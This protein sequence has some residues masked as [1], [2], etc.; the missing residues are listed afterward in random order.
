MDDNRNFAFTIRIG[1]YRPM[2]GSSYIPT[3]KVLAGKHAIVNVCNQDDMCFAWAVLS[4]MHSPK[5]HAQKVFNYRRHLN[6]IDLTGIKFPTPINQVG[7]F[8]KNNPTLSINVY[9]LGKDEKEIIPKYVT[10]CG[11]RQKHIDLLLLTSDEKSHYV[12]IKNMSALICHRSKCK[13]AVFVCP[14]CVHPFTSKKA[15]D[16]HFDDCAKHKYQVTRY[17]KEYTQESILMWRSREKTERLPFVIYADFESC[18]V[19]VQNR[20]NVVDEHV[21]SGFC[22]YTVSTDAEFETEPFL[23]SGPDCMEVFYEHLAQEQ[24]RIVDIMRLNVDM[25]PL[26][27]EEQQRFDQ[28]QWCPRCYETFIHGN[29]KV[30]HHNHRTGKFI[31]ALCNNCNLQ[32]GDRILIPVVFHNLK[33]YDAHHIFKSFNKRVAAKYDE[34]G[35]ETFESVN[36]IALNLEKYVTFEFQYLRFIDSCQFL[37]ASLDKLVKN[38]PRE[39]LRHARKHLGDNDLLYAKGIFPY[40]WF[41]TFNKFDDAELPP[42]DSFYSNL[43]EE[44]ITEE[45]YARARNVWTTFECQKFKD[46]HDLYLK[47]DV[48]LL[49]DVFENFRDLS[50]KT[51]ELDPAQYVTTPSLTWDACLKHTKISLDL[52]TDAEMFTFF[53]SGMRGGISV[54]SNR[55]AR[56]N[57]PYLKPEDYDK[58]KPNSYIC[59]LDANNL[60]GWAMSQY[61]PY[62]KFRFM[63]DEEIEQLDV[64]TVPDDAETGYVLECDLEYPRGLHDLHNDYPLAPEHMT[65]NESMLS[66]F[67]TSM[68]A[69]HVFTEKLI[70]SLQ[71]KIKYKV[72]YRNLKLYLSLGM[73]LIKVHRVVVFKQKPWLKSYIE[74][75]TRLRQMAKSEFEKDF[76]KLMNNACF[77][78][79]MEN[80]R[81]RRTVEIVGDPTKFRKLIAKPQTEQ[82]LIINEDM[83]LVDRM[84]KEVLLNK[85]IYVGFTV[86]D[87]SKLLIFDYHYNVMVKRYGSNA[88][89]LFNDTDSLCYHLFTDDVYRDMSEYLDLLDTSGYPRDHPLYSAVNAKVIGK[90]KDECNG[91]APLEFVGL[92]AKMYSLLTYDDSMAKRTAKGIKKRYVAKHLRHDMY[93]RTLRD[94][95]I[96]HAKYRLFR[97]RAHTIE[98]VEYSKVALCAY[99]DKRYV[100]ND[101]VATLA[102]GHVRLSGV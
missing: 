73:K 94:K 82:F 37:N 9:M 92:R 3:P 55:F 76:F 27:A 70:G 95:T 47:T 30:R 99:D 63:S 64:T 22:A 24:A 89:L 11:K 96:E 31:D 32:I 12:W 84:K 98:T 1:Q 4:A 7:R 83:V 48:I 20:S 59:Y 40:E 29:E 72:H 80:V 14:H 87:V 26:T 21:P 66:P 49:A 58:T 68:N 44:G 13:N 65:I 54:I 67:C 88:R 19:P 85:P 90:M 33:N 15:F 77:G 56:A 79:S 91:K 46:Y 69:N 93:L 42:R 60:Y 51:Y 41:D 71:T 28:A 53:E 97:S 75:N 35:R 45:E 6:T 52:I 86:L 16:N 100:L 43:N 2:T 10:K 8:E 39:S 18:L 36:I 81:N 34:E 38:L 62:E 101:G 61:L 102:Y 17:P 23:Y 74:L 57:N 78:K 5:Y 25:L 50:L